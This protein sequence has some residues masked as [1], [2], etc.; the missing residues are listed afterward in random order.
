MNHRCHNLHP[1]PQHHSACI[2]IVPLRIPTGRSILALHFRI[3]GAHCG[4]ALRRNVLLG[5]PRGA[6]RYMSLS[7]LVNHF[8][9]S[10]SN[11]Y[12]VRLMHEI[13]GLLHVIACCYMLL[14]VITCYYMILHTV[15]CYYMLRKLHVITCYYMNMLLTDIKCNLLLS[16]DQQ[17]AKKPFPLDTKR[18]P[19]TM[20]WYR[21]VLD[22]FT[23]QGLL[24]K[25]ATPFH[26]RV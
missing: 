12:I 6:I 3:V 22:L 8:D 14:H 24:G 18:E 17:M 2:G 10:L 15:T 19:E 5:Q 4:K 25:C 16:T 26:P 11:G 9:W 7:W 13:Y 1:S 23:S 20:M 21:N